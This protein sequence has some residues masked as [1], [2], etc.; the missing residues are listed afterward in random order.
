MQFEADP[1]DDMMQSLAEAL[2]N[3]DVVLIELLVETNGL[4]QDLKAIREGS[5]RSDATFRCPPNC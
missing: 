4:K 5:A 1:E 3:L 2:H